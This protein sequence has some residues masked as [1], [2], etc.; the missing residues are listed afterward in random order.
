MAKVL[1]TG[2]TGFL[3]QHLIRELRAG[4]HEVRGLVRSDGAEAALRA[5]GAEPVRGD[6]DD[7]ASVGAA[8][9]SGVDAVFHSAADTNT[10]AMRNA[11]QTRTNVEG[12]R[13]LVEAALQY[14]VGA[15]IHTSSVASFSHLV[16]G[17]LTEDSPR[18]G[19]ESWINYERTKFLAEEAV[20][21]GMRRGLRAVIV[22]PAHIFGPGDTRNWARLI[23]LIDRGELPGAPPGVGAFADVREVARAQVRAFERQRFGESYLLGGE[24]ASFV[25]LIGRIGQLLG[26]KVPR[27]ATPALVL[28]AYARGLDWV[29]RLTRRAPE[30]TPE[31]ATFTCHA[32]RVDS[33]KAIRA[34]DY[35]LTPLD[36][37]LFDT[38]A[39]LRAAGMLSAP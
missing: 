26:R 35:R 22:Y 36:V 3:G 33:S 14:Q 32:L 24:H 16:P 5:L 6:L 8:L 37:L 1:V 30:I 31:A 7:A 17:T 25:D 12:T 13:A 34:L 10:W 21:D 18:L 20:R 9:A 23:Q 2:A 28:K 4:G 15:F 29:S 38:V 11:Q 19:G 27:R 39:W